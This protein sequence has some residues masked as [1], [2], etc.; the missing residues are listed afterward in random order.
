MTNKAPNTTELYIVFFTA[1]AFFVF[2]AG[3]IIYFIV[4]YQ[5]KQGQ[6][7]VERENLQANFRQ[8]FLKAR[9]EIQEQTFAHVSREI[10]DNITQVLSFIKLNLAMIGNTDA[11]QQV[12]ISENRE[13]I[14]QVITDLRDLSK[15]L[16]FEHIT[17][18]GL[19]KTIKVEINRVNKSGLIDTTFL[20]EGDMYALGKQ[21]ELVLFRIFQEA[22][23]NTLKHSEAKHLK[24]GLQY[25][26]ELFTLTL[27]DDGV[28]FSA[29]SLTQ[30]GS[31]LKNMENRATLIGA[32]TTIN[33]SPGKGCYIKVCLN[34]LEERLYI[35]GTHPDR[36]S[37]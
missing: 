18:F 4:L 22:L 9:L 26:P 34:P 8:E 15:S 29:D 10:H 13:L 19:I 14:A 20:V 25:V 16:S 33:S 7:K 12:K 11:E 5:K 17:K 37:R 24:I 23:N 1:T 21:T 28:G 6:N 35:D 31:G 36:L 30:R 32:V 27:E 3:F 2:L